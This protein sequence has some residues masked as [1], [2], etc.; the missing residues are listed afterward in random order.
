[1]RVGQIV[2]AQV[3]AVDTEKRQMK[4][5]MKQLVPT[6]IDEYIAEHKRGDEVTGR[7]VDA[8]GSQVLVELG[9]GIRAL[10]ASAAPAA[11]A[12]KTASAPKP[13]AKVDLSSLSSMLKARWKGDV[14]DPKAAS[15]P[16]AEGQIRTFKIVKIDPD[17]K[18]IEVELA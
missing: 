8:S 12:A 3:L 1:L 4:L 18:R 10:C 15:E 5:S 6:D 13:A 17:A 7:I 2:K 16:L 11:P 9:E 14:P